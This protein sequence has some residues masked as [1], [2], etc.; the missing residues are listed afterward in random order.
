MPDGIS[1]FETPQQ[2]GDAI[3]QLRQTSPKCFHFIPEELFDTKQ[4]VIAVYLRTVSKSTI[5][6]DTSGREAPYLKF[7]HFA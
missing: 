1:T 7:S 4:W 5:V 2:C 3:S 6:R